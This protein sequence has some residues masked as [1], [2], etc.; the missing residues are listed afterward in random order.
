MIS[1]EHRRAGLWEVRVLHQFLDHQKS[2]SSG[3]ESTED[4][5]ASGWRGDMITMFGINQGAGE[6][7]GAFKALTAT[8]GADHTYRRQQR[9]GGPQGPVGMAR[10]CTSTTPLP[11]H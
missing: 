3:S 2:V 9:Q 6:M 11:R 10:C 1:T 4:G 5:K 7:G 8:Q